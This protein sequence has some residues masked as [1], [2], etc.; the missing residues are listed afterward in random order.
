MWWSCDAGGGRVHDGRGSSDRGCRYLHPEAQGFSPDALIASAWVL[1]RQADDQ[2]LDLLVQRR[3]PRFTTRTGPCAGDQPPMAAQQGLGLD[4]EP[5]P[6]S[7]R[8]RTADRGEQRPI[9]GLQPGSWS[10]AA[11]HGELVTRMD[12]QVLGGVAAGRAGRGARWS[13]TTSGRQVVAAPGWPPRWGSGGA[14]VASQGRCE[15]PSLWALSEYL[16]LTGCTTGTGSSSIIREPSD[17]DPDAA[18]RWPPIL[19][20]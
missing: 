12:L 14:T 20:R 7:P 6:A 4:E 17:R 19:G 10:L 5:R 1:P 11:E 16:H 15:P 3:P 13:G 2:L 8:Q 18:A 9:G